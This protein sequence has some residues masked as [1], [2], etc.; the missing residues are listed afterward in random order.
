M[1][2]NTFDVE[3]TV[4]DAKDTWPSITSGFTITIRVNFVCE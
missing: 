1:R 4:S 2:A 3:N